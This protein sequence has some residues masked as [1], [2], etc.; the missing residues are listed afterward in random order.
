MSWHLGEGGREHLVL[1]RRSGL[2][3]GWQDRWDAFRLV[4]PNWTASFPGV[5]TT[6]RIPD[7]FMPRDEIAGGLPATRPEIDAP[8]ELETE[9]RRL[10]SANGPVP[11]RDDARVARGPGGGRGDGRVP[12]PATGRRSPSSLPARSTSSTRT[13]TATPRRCRPG[14]VLVVG[15]GQSGVQIAEELH[16]A[17]RTVFLSVGSGRSLPAPVPRAATS[18]A[19]WPGSPVPATRSGPRCRRST[20]WPTRDSGWP[21]TRTAR[22]TAAATT[23]TS[24]GSPPRG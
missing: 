21:G 19:G 18:S 5:A 17:G 1:E 6:A 2:G 8:V 24:A 23:R 13:T 12:R 9:V 10:R 3:G 22:D 11:P 16:D 14:A 15:S 7:G 20:G 4:S